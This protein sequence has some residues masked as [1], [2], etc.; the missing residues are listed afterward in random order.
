MTMRI[1]MLAIA[2]AGLAGCETTMEPEQ[3]TAQAQ[4]NY[5]RMLAGKVAGPPE[6]CLPTF[7]SSDMV[8]IDEN[9]ILFRDG[10]AV[11]VNHP[12]GG[13]NRL[14]RGGY[15]LV[16]RNFGPRLCRGDIATVADLSTGTVAGS[17]ALGEFIPYRPAAG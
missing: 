11:Y 12:P 6:Q 4:A 17:C 7:R 2:A 3:R 15:A 9:T 5:D 16:T 1:L 14:G 10:S 8:A 13:C